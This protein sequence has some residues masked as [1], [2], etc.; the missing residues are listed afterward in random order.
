M[1]VLSI[2][3]IAATLAAASLL[4]AG[5]PLHALARASSAPAHLGSAAQ[6]EPAAERPTSSRLSLRGAVVAAQAHYPTIAAAEANRDAAASAVGEAKAARWPTLRLTGAA[7]RYEEPMLVTP[8]HAFQVDALPPFNETILQ[9][10]LNA[11]WTL[12]DGWARGARIDAASRQR[13]ASESALTAT[14]QDLVLR[15]VRAYLHV[16]TSAQV[17]EAQDQRLTALTAERERAA[18]LLAAGRAAEV[19]VLRAEA[20][21]ASAEAERIRLAA[22]LD[23]A[24]H[25]LARVAGMAPERVQRA[26]LVAVALRDTTS[27]DRAT[28]HEAARAASPFLQQS[29]QRLAA[30]AA[31]AQVARGRRW[32]QLDLFGNSIGWSDADGHDALEWNAGAQLVYPIFTGGAI[33]KGIDKADALQTASQEAVRIDEIQVEQDIDRALAR[34]VETH[35]RVRSLRTAVERYIEVVRIERLSLD[36]GS[37]TQTDYLRAEADLLE[38]RAGLVEAQHGEMAA[39]AELARVTGELDADWIARTLE[40]RP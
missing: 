16:L 20:A 17:L 1:T 12:F 19:E 32:P 24:Q 39:R 31:Q 4:L 15:V 34:T 23:I 26:P 14:E 40:D 38:A 33:S 5:R 30:S 36:A 29:R 22:L 13:D 21:R 6:G 2:L 8:I 25:D 9:G 7:T 18:R 28:L 10:T 37:G 35:A 11:S 3:R 27:P